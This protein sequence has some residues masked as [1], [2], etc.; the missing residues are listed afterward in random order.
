MVHPKDRIKGWV[1]FIQKYDVIVG[2]RTDNPTC[3]EG[4][5]HVPTAPTKTNN[6]VYVVVDG[7]QAISVLIVELG[8]VTE[9][10]PVLVKLQHIVCLL[11]YLI[12]FN[13]HL[14]VKES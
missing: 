2:R 7:F 1:H 13:S 5:G 4:M 10:F 3:E 11:P 8:M 14:P 9:K 6:A 12:G